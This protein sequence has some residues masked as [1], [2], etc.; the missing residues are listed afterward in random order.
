MPDYS[1]ISLFVILGVVYVGGA[2]LGSRLLGTK[3]KDYKHKHVPYECGV[4]P[5][6]SARI[7]FKIGYYLFALVFM[8]FDVEALFLFPCVVVYKDLVQ[9]A[10]VTSDAADV[11]ASAVGSAAGNAAQAASIGG[12]QVMLEL[13]V[14]I[15][16]LGLGLL[17]AWKKGILEWE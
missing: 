9:P 8:V 10:V 12:T 6:G 15:A 13:L 4:L 1:V 17:F 3:G 11:V 7:Q 16:I 14:F 5:Y 2:I